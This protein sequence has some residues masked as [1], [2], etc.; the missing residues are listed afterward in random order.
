MSKYFMFD[1][2]VECNHSH[3]H[4]KCDGDEWSVPA[5]ESRLCEIL[6]KS[7]ELLVFYER[8]WTD[9]QYEYTKRH[10]ALEAKSFYYSPEQIEEAKDWRK[11]GLT[12]EQ[13]R[14]RHNEEQRAE[15]QKLF[16][17]CDARTYAFEKFDKYRRLAT[18]AKNALN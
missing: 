14:I 3:I 17:F 16:G 13:E 9:L 4:L 8:M 12:A 10:A 6:H 15:W 1:A 2:V 5:T 11:Y 7:N 18:Q